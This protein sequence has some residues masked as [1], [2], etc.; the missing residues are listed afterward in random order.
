MAGSR[1]ALFNNYMDI[2]IESKLPSC[3]HPGVRMMV[4]FRANTGADAH[5]PIPTNA[6]TLAAW[7]LSI[8]AFSQLPQAGAP[9]QAVHLHMD[10]ITN[11][12]IMTMEDTGVQVTE[13]LWIMEWADIEQT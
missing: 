6:P 2:D 10:T 8:Q 13:Q 11:L 9:A 7:G 1:I 5:C 4:M 3:E 12:A